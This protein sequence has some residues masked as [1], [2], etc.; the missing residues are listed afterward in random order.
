MDV[1]L[2]GLQRGNQAKDERCRCGEPERRRPA[3]PPADEAARQEAELEAKGEQA[4]RT[5]D[6]E[7]AQG[8]VSGRPAERERPP[9]LTFTPP[10][11]PTELPGVD[12]YGLRLVATRTLYDRG[13]LVAHSPSLRPLARD[14]CLRLN[15][16]DLD[17][18][19]LTSGDQVT[20]SAPTGRKVTLTALVEAGVP[21]GVAAMHVN[22]DGGDP[23]ELIDV[24]SPVTTIQVE[25][26]R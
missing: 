18:L 21:K 16:T 25:T 23:A 6:A 3:A 12:A 11:S 22:H 9:L 2:R 19:G 1:A 10:S 7:A 14:A 13:T 26:N 17:R 5:G 20:L 24:T 4:G 15:Q 8:A